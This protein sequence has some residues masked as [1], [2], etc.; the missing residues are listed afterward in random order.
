MIAS[1]YENRSVCISPGTYKTDFIP[2]LLSRWNS[3][4]S[5][6]SQIPT[7]YCGNTT[8][9]QSIIWSDVAIS[10]CTIES[11]PHLNITLSSINL[12]NSR[13][14]L[15]NPQSL[16]M[17]RCFL[18]DCTISVDTSLS[19]NGTSFTIL[20][21]AFRRQSNLSVHSINVLSQFSLSNNSIGMGS[22]I[23]IQCGGT[24]RD[25]LI[26]GNEGEGQI[27][28]N[29]VRTSEPSVSQSL[30]LVEDNDMMDITLVVNYAC[31]IS[32]N[33]GE[34]FILNLDKSP[35][36]HIVRSIEMSDNRW[37]RGY[38]W[39]RDSE[40][41]LLHIR[42]NR[43][44]YLNLGQVSSKALKLNV[45]ENQIG[46]LVVF[47]Y[48][49]VPY[50]AMDI[51]AYNTIGRL[52]FTSCPTIIHRMNLLRNNFT[53]ALISMN[54]VDKR[55]S[56]YNLIT[57]QHCRWNGGND[58]AL[59]ISNMV[60]GA[61]SFVHNEISDYTSLEGGGL[62][63]FNMESTVIQV[64]NNR[65]T[66][67]RANV[68]G[69]ISI[70]NSEAFLSIRKNFF[71]ENE[72][73]TDSGAI[74]VQGASFQEAYFSNNL[75]S[76]NRAPHASV[77]SIVGLY[78]PQIYDNVILVDCLPG[79]DFSLVSSSRPA[80]T[81]NTIECP[82]GHKFV[83]ANST[84]STRS[85]YLWM[86]SPCSDGSYLL[87][88]G[89][90]KNGTLINTKCSPCP[91]HVTCTTEKTPQAQGGY[92][93]AVDD[94]GEEFTCHVCPDQY[95]RADDH[96]WNSSCNDN[97]RGVLCGEC[98][99]GY[100]LA[101][102]TSK[103]MPREQCKRGYLSFVILLPLA[104]AGLLIILPIGDG[105]V[106]KSLSFFLQTFPLLMDRDL[107]TRL[108]GIFTFFVSP[109]SQGSTSIGFCAGNFDY[110]TVQLFL[111]YVPMGTLVLLCIGCLSA[112]IT[113]KIRHERR[114]LGTALI[115]ASLLVYSGVL[116]ICL[117]L[118][119][120]VEIEG[121][122][123]V[124]YNAGT[125]SCETTWRKLSA[126]GAAVVLVPFPFF[127]I[128]LRWESTTKSKT[129]GDR[130]KCKYGTS[131]VSRDV[132]MVLEGCYRHKYRYWETVYVLRRFAVAAVYVF[133]ANLLWTSSIMQL[134][135][136]I[137][138]ASHA[139]VR[140]FKAFQGQMLET[141]CLLSLVCLS[142]TSDSSF[143]YRIY[144]E[145]TWLKIKRKWFGHAPE[146]EILL[147]DS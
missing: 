13:L 60:S 142:I 80:N 129:E 100:T 108:S 131:E 66:R 47:R 59:K 32:R 18:D 7:I 61:I 118:L 119:F 5:D 101:F 127:L 51:M 83:Y 63:L 82:S 96:D 92:W 114:S 1:Q 133:T 102:L 91:D 54:S 72:G 90:L 53:T 68:G 123:Q 22:S 126:A 36:S 62:L 17:I 28:L 141:I 24:E 85:S 94:G 111:L 76:H 26:Q 128:L 3:N 95:C 144:V 12:Q 135:M 105:S 73:Y 23:R 64:V 140:P 139:V 103:C 117:K 136:V 33:R 84:T 6:E 87:G 121:H 31:K 69:A 41:N 143:Q 58:S 27:F 29:S 138:F 98:E 50:T 81:S 79:S 71:I 104:Y 122:G 70:T 39:M 89:E 40:V 9:Q 52:E 45:S 115:T 145:N 130:R 88:A 110:I 125:I 146:M 106:W 37:N 99:E 2:S 134:L 93:C 67:C 86:C 38:I 25:I 109:G 107:I 55:I 147:N 11:S 78:D 46:Q 49:C 15:K 35:R 16:Q 97:R 8:V 112:I 116:S 113:G 77:F 132:L 10:G 4:T 14:S 43:M 42:G 48:Q 34:G 21:N 137:I 57:V 74:S 75:F 120:C 124:M 56:E 65:F 44:S 19:T 20:E 30:L